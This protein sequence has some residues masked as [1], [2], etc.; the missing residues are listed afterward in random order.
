MDDEARTEWMYRSELYVTESG[1]AVGGCC[2][3]FV[4]VVVVVVVVYDKSS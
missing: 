4:V 1:N 3:S 2:R